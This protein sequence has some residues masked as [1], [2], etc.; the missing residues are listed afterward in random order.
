MKLGHCRDVDKPRLCHTE[1]S[2]SEREKQVSSINACMWNLEK[3]YQWPYVQS[4]NTDI[5]IENKC[6]DTK[7]E[8]GGEG[9]IGRLG[10]T[11]WYYWYY[12]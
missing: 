9:G 1:W 11:H 6:I 12:V 4:R 8:R 3:W 2:K 10:L 7:G 5:D